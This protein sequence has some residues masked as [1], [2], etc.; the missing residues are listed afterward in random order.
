MLNEEIEI[1][2]RALERERQAKF[3]AEEFVEKRLYELY[4]ENINLDKKF[5]SQ[6]QFQE[7]L[8]DNLVDALFVIDFKGNIIQ[9]NK[10][11][12]KLIGLK[13][14][15]EF[16]KS[17]SEFS[18]KNSKEL[19]HIFRNIKQDIN[20]ELN[21]EW[22]FVNRQKH[23]KKVM[24]KSRLLQDYNGKPHAIQAIVRD[25]TTQ[26]ELD[27]KLKRRYELQK[28]EALILN[29][30]LT[31]NSLYINAWSLVHH[32][33]K[34]LKSDDCVFYSCIDD[35]LIQIAAA[36]D[37]L[38]PDNKTIKNK[39]EI[40]ITDGIVGQ[41]ARTKKGVIIHDT[42]KTDNY[43]VDDVIRLSEITIP[44]IL[45]DK[46]I[47]IIDSEHPERNHYSQYQ[48]DFLLKISTA[49]ALTIRN[50]NIELEKKLNNQELLRTKNRLESIFNSVHNAEV[51]ESI[52]GNIIDVGDAFFNL[53]GFPLDQKPSFIGISC[54]NARNK[55]KLFFKEEDKFIQ[56]IDELIQSKETVQHEV[57][58]LKDGRFLS[59]DFIPVFLNN[60]IDCFLWRYRDVTLSVN[61]EKNI[62]FE[63]IK[64]KSIIEGMNL[65]LLE[66]N[67]KGNI[68]SVNA[69]FCK[70]SGYS[71]EE[72]LGKLAKN[73][74]LKENKN[75]NKLITNAEKR[76]FKGESDAYELPV[77][78]KTGEKRNWLI[79]GS[80]NINVNKEVVG[81]IGIHLDITEIK[82]LNDKNDKLISNLT[83][84][85]EEL[86]HYAHL[87]SH[88]LKTPLRTI[89]TFIN[90]ID[91]E[92]EET[93]SADSKEY[94]RTI[95][96]TISDMDKLISS[97][98]Q[99]AEIRSSI[100]DKNKPINLLEVIKSL[101]KKYFSHYNDFKIN[102]PKALPIVNFNET[103][104]KQI[105]QNLIDNSF[106]Y[107]DV[108]K[109]SF[110]SISYEENTDHYVFI[111]E[112]NGIG[113]DELH[114]HMVFTIFKKMNQRTDSSGIGLW[115]TKKIIENAGGKVWFE[116]KLGE[117][118]TFYF[119]VKK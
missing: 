8:I 115:I 67:K 36:G 50:S 111:V 49:I 105:F 6:S 35:K 103:Q 73:I 72:L 19:K 64:Y 11:A 25:I 119:T 14:Y 40:P 79:S 38:N 100:D 74:L 26:Y 45:G 116:S 84:S 18:I 77:V 28:F 82:Q 39:L 71:R 107:K 1:L 112:D 117:G 85:N 66:V 9:S 81:S 89:S 68:L 15:E 23:E 95:E 65:G 41:V 94:I 7:L 17:I 47:G 32:I 78:T 62:E 10:E 33:A 57:L 52:E 118:T 29:D 60:K 30:L 113:I 98:L 109:S 75:A 3:V 22:T 76:R 91:E 106:K 99:F 5:K 43:I 4:S 96:E 21:L 56:R 34:F 46:L 24:I 88:D 13:L 12:R 93:L 101:I 48:L 58:E 114:H 51:V 61:Y 59:R 27:L 87:V 90:Y 42:E 80:S 54:V 110:V 37:K 31:E 92:N 70:M 83:S 53:F 102:L 97:T 20:K 104:I 69:A 2:K 108:N 86:S 63:K 16:P 44:I 55:L